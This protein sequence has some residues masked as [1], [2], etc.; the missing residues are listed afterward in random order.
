MVEKGHNYGI[1]KKCNKLHINPF[2]GKTHSEESKRKISEGHLGQKNHK[3]KGN[4]V[5]YN[6]LHGWVKNN[7]PKPKL[8]ERCKI[9]PPYDLANISGK[10]KRDVNDFEWICRKCHMESDGRMI[11]MKQGIRNG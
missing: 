5:G 2:K 7:K 6:A 1:C 11:K 4:E 10:Y 8:C 3:W 9:K